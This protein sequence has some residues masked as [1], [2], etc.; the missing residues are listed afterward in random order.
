[1]KKTEKAKLE[2][3]TAKIAGSCE[4]DLRRRLLAGEVEIPPRKAM[5]ISRMAPPMRAAQARSYAETGGPLELPTY[6]DVV[7]A[8]LEAARAR[9]GDGDLAAAL[10]AVLRESGGFPGAAMPPLDTEKYAEL[11]YRL[12]RALGLVAKVAVNLPRLGGIVPAE[13]EAEKLRERLGKLAEFSQLIEGVAE[14]PG[15]AEAP[16]RLKP[17]RHLRPP[18]GGDGLDALPVPP[19]QARL[20]L[21]RRLLDFLRQSQQLL[22]EVLPVLLRIAFRLDLLTRLLELRPGVFGDAVH[23]VNRADVVRHAVAVAELAVLER[24]AV[25]LLLAHDTLLRDLD[26]GIVPGVDLQWLSAVPRL[27]RRVEEGHDVRQGRVLIDGQPAPQ[28]DRLQTHPGRRARLLRLLRVEGV[29]VSA[30]AGDDGVLMP[31]SAG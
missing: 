6:R 23:A 30:D 26:G 4:G 1:M 2:E 3:A 20:L 16:N 18:H 27:R 14:L 29:R 9:R 28:Q 21:L 12:D 25:E 8:A 10:A 31:P 5:E 15:Q 7:D 19:E 11:I 22:D 24:P 13:G 17:E